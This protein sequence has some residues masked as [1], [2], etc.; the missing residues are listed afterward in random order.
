MENRVTKMKK[1]LCFFGCFL[2]LCFATKT[3][4]IQKS[5]ANNLSDDE[6]DVV[7][8]LL[9]TEL[10]DKIYKYHT[11]D[12]VIIIKEAL[13][14]KQ[15]IEDYATFLNYFEHSFFDS[16]QI[17]NLKKSLEKEP[18]YYWKKTDFDNKRIGLQTREDL[19]KSIKNEDYLN[20]PDRLIFYLSTPFFIDKN[21]ALVTFISGSGLLGFNLINSAVVLLEKNADGK[22]KTKYLGSKYY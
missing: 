18:L 20:S 2:F 11:N 9:E 3:K 5:N 6:R 13:T 16:I 10:S 8:I 1:A 17:A 15:V 4:N 19:E 12:S 22:W 14:K 7:N 21:K